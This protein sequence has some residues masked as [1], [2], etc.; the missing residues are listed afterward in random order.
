MVTTKQ[1]LA[2]TRDAVSML[3]STDQ[4]TASAA[5]LA[6]A[7]VSASEALSHRGGRRDTFADMARCQYLAACREMATDS[8]VEGL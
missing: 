2:I 7:I 6:D 4:H 8:R 5:W 1:L 3:P